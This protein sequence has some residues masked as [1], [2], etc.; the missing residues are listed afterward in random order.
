[1]ATNNHEGDTSLLSTWANNFTRN[2]SAAFAQMR[3]QDYIRLIVIIGGYCLLR[4]YLM[5]LGAKMQTK[6]HEKD[7][8]EGAGEA[9][10]HPNELRGKVEIP[11]VEDSDEEEEDE[12]AKPGDWGR[13]ARVRQ[14]K[15]IR[16]ALEREEQRLRDEQEAESDKDIEEFLVE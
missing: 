2:T 3:L 9:E 10:I 11:G 12:E 15:F 5:K 4:P 8:V 6:A 16:E 14:R 1:M 7:A 13:N